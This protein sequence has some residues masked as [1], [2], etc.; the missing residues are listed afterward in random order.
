[1]TIRF[2][3]L[4]SVLVISACSSRVEIK[5]PHDLTELSADAVNINTASVADLERLPFVGRTTAELIVAF[6]ELH[7][8]FRHSEQLMLI[9]GISETR[10]FEI[11]HLLR[12]R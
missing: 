11:R 7:G 6:R 1:M 10:F 5:T 12:T 4:I 2:L 3:F 8:P 9:R